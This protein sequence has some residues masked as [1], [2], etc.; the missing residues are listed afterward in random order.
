[1]R[2]SHPAFIQETYVPQYL[3]LGRHGESEANAGLTKTA[4]GLYYSNSGSDPTVPLTALGLE[5]AEAV[6][7][8]LAQ[9]FPGGEIAI[10]R[11]FDND[12]QRVQ[13]FAEKVVNGIGYPVRRLRD[14][15]LNKRSYGD[16]WNL[17]YRG[18]RELHPHEWKRFEEMGPLDYRPPNGENYPDLF[19]RVDEFIE[20]EI[21]PNSENTLVLTSSVV[22]LSFMRNLEQ[23]SDEEL[24]RQYEQQCV[25]NAQLVVY[26]RNA[27]GEPWCRCDEVAA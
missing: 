15:R 23:L 9:L 26:R 21:Q 20:Q 6:A 3:V 27:V 14:S 11:A 18:V 19:T 22:V 24:L 1:M 16:F 7:R 8:R 17:T 10:E 13:S 4:C 12:Y 25:V 2:C 5:Q